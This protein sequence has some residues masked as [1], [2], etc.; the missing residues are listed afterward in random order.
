MR[1]HNK[2]VVVV[3]SNCGGD[4]DDDDYDSGDYED[5]CNDN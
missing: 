3:G 1:N 5:D 2:L 4:D